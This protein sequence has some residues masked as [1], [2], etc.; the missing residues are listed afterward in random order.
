MKPEEL[1]T[2]YL[3]GGMTV[4]EPGPGMGFFTLPMARMT[5]PAGRIIAVD[6]QERM[7]EGLRRRARKAG[8]QERI[9][10]RLA[11]PESMGTDDLAG[12]VNF[13]LAFAVVHEL[14]SAEG[15]FREAYAAMKRGAVLLLAE[16]KGHVT[17]ERFKAE[18]KSGE[19][20][21]LEIASRPAI[22]GSHAAVFT[23]TA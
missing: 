14:P 19:D 15:F 7:L 3:R 6:I 17:P 9:E 21:G 4:L 20:A 22:A 16:P 13:V 2:P 5:G 11:Q 8:V 18:L 10:A 12:K 23:K 1:L